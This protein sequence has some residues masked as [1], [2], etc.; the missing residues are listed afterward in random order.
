VQADPFFEYSQSGLCIGLV[1]AQP[2]MCQHSGTIE[3]RR[4]GFGKGSDFLVRSTRRKLQTP[5]WKQ[6]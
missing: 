4:D 2:L 6:S 1:L 3:A 5:Q